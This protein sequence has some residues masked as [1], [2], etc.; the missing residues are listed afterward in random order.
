MMNI[1]TDPV[2]TVTRARASTTMTLPEVL[3]ACARDEIDDFPHIRAFQ[4]HPWH[5]LLAQL[6][7]IAAIDS[8]L[9]GMPDDE[10]TWTQAL[11]ALTKDEFPGQEPWHLVVEDQE[12]PAFLQPPTMDPGFTR[13]SPVDRS[14]DTID[15]TVGSRRHEVKDG[16]IG[17]P[18]PDHWIYA[19]TSTQT[20]NGYTGKRQHGISRMNLG[21]ANR[22]GF[23]ITPSTRWG[24]HI[25]RDAAV[26]ARARQGSPVRHL[27]L[28]TRP[29][30]GKKGETIAL[31]ELEPRELYIEICRRLRLFQDERGTVRA[32]R[33]TSLSPRLDAKEKLGDVGDPWT[34]V[35]KGKA[36]I[37]TASGFTCRATSKY[38]DPALSR[39]P[40]LAQH[41]PETDGDG[42]MY[43]VARTLT[44]G[45]GKT[46][47]YHTLTIPMS[48]A[49]AAMLD[50]GTRQE[51]LAAAAK[52]RIDIIANLETILSASLKTYSK[53]TEKAVYAQS[54]RLEAQAGE[55]FWADLQR[56]LDAPDPAEELVR[57]THRTLVPM[58]RRLLQR[59]Q[60]Q[61]ATVPRSRYEAI[62]ASDGIFYGMVRR[63]KVLPA[64]PDTKEEAAAE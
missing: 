11:A 3:A 12:K 2:I 45:R 17:R 53:V 19:L 59:S 9:T 18:L 63:S 22:H 54:N 29:W 41:H 28:W 13:H 35:Q 31:E 8:G 5:A 1:L 52:R 23:S 10:A 33:G 47:G 37:V 40:L 50:Q 30:A 21:Y 39:I 61:L 7:A 26:L 36:T 20:S 25:M 64:R 24:R 34:L 49:M 58:A 57:W 51:R 55:T 32:A 48:N 4:E 16:I 43:L 60:Q 14:P 6:A 15:L 42:P 46:A 56:E 44:R 62:S 38:L 27:L